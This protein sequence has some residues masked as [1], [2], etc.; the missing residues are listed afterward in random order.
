MGQGEKN[1]RQLG[2]GLLRRG[3]FVWGLILAGTLLL[4]LP[5]KSREKEETKTPETQ[6]LQTAEG[7]EIRLAETLSQVE[8]AGRVEVLLSAQAGQQYIPARNVRLREDGEETEAEE[9]ILVLSHSGGDEETVCLQVLAEQYRGA[10]I[11]AEGGEDPTVA[12]ALTRAV[13]AVTGL[14]ADRITVMKMK[15]S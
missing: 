11:V 13:S 9:E 15:R 10:V 3:W 5:G 7:L 1:F 12:L 8:G 6:P 14:G 4:L 2:K